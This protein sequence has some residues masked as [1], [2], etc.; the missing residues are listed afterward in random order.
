MPLRVAS[1]RPGKRGM[2][3]VFC[4][5]PELA[6]GRHREHAVCVLDFELA[7]WPSLEHVSWYVTGPGGLLTVY[8]LLLDLF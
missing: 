8:I 5:D 4:S 3:T 2:D 1:S 7:G 6:P